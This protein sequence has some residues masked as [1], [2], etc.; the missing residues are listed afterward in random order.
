MGSFSI[1]K[2]ELLF[3]SS[4]Y[5]ASLN[6]EAAFF[7]W[8]SPHPQTCFNRSNFFRYWGS[9]VYTSNQFFLENLCLSLDMIFLGIGD[10]MS[11]LKSCLCLKQNKTVMCK[12]KCFS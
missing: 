3:V 8:A 12:V 7:F 10:A 4:F 1:S 11:T 2:L 6:F 9:S 5:F